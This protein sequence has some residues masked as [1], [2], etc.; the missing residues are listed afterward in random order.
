MKTKQKYDRYY[1]YDEITAL[2]KQYE[3]EY[4][5]YFRLS[6]I[7]QTP[8]KR[9]IWLAEVTDLSAGD[10]AAKPGFAID[11]NVHAGE[12]TGS[13]VCMYF[14]DVL[15][16]GKDDPAI[17][18]LLKKYT[19]YCV[20]R[21]SP[22]GSEFYLTT[23]YSVRSSSRMF[24]YDEE[25]PGIIPEDLDGDGVIR[26]MRVKRP[27]GL[28]R[29]SPEDPRLMT[30]RRPD[31]TEGDFY[32]VFPEGRVVGDACEPVPAPDKYGEDFNRNF[33]GGWGIGGRGGAYGL[34]APETKA[35]AEFLSAHKNICSCLNFHTAMGCYLYPPAMKSQKQAAP[36]DMAR[37]KELGKL[38]TEITGYPFVNL[39]D[40]F[41]GSTPVGGSIDDFG[42]YVLGILSFTCECW[43]LQARCGF[44]LEFPRKMPVPDEKQEAYYR[45]VLKWIDENN[46]GE[47]WRDWQKFDHPVLGEVEIGGI[48]SKFIVQNPPL[49]YLEQELEKH[50]KFM[51]R[52]MAALPLLAVSSLQT[53]DHGS[54]TEIVLTVTNTGYFPT[55]VT[56]E[57]V[58]VGR[59]RDITVKLEG[60]ATADGKNEVRIGQL[61]G[62]AL[63]GSY[64][65]GQGGTTVGRRPG[66]KTVRFF[67]VGE[68]GSEV[69]VTV[70]SQRAGILTRKIRLG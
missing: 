69:T 8:E 52:E 12:V 50:A 31:E 40:D 66:K 42:H 4:P 21:I 15:L 38:C 55:D 7:G 39:H 14:L 5:G 18:A 9:E 26:R 57:A 11:G 61:S 37:Y 68:R 34:S 23:P 32:D 47:G 41:L 22:D 16:S 20:P 24:P 29:I 49:R 67:A 30:M 51:L 6:S 17:A 46:A 58:P 33:P 53:I 63:S 10:F 62:H 56:A 65:R 48:D 59:V 60:A 3:K 64:G 25:Q 1:R 19:V 28:F 43:D 2:L 54:C 44:P 36:E 13:M 45:A 35:F 70:S 27:N